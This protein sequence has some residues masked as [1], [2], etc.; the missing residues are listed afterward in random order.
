MAKKTL[1]SLERELETTSRLAR[2]KSIALT[3]IMEH[4]ADIR[5]RA[6]LVLERLNEIGVSDEKIQEIGLLDLIQKPRYVDLLPKDARTWK[7]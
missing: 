4:N 6:K 3:A 7:S 1:A 5:H 2:R